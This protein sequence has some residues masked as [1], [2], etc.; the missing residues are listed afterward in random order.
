MPDETGADSAEHRLRRL[1]DVEEIRR[2][3][4]AYCRLSDRGYAAAGDDPAG[5]A[6]LFAED[7][8]WQSEGGEPAR[9]RAAIVGLFEQ[10]RRQLPF[11]L[12]VAA[13]PAIDVDGDR[14]SCSWHGVMALTTS[15]GASLWVGGVYEDELVRTPDGWRFAAI[16][17]RAAFT[18]PRA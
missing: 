2:L 8:V 15:D 6:A 11:A 17:F 16:T 5:V 7:G 18:G 3:K 13:N 12:H 4:A 10:F 9:G 1:E 14:A